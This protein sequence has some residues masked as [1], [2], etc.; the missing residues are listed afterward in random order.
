MS[1]TQFDPD[2]YL[3]EPSTKA[4]SFN[5][6]EYL[7]G[8][9]APAPA[10]PSQ[11]EST[12]RGAVQGVTLGFSDEAKGIAVGGL[13]Y[14]KAKVKGTQ[15][16]GLKS[17]YE[18]ARDIERQANKAAQAAS[19]MAYGAGSLAGGVAS[20]FIPGL[21]IAKGAGLA[22]AAGKSALGAGLSALGEAEGTIAEQARST[23]Q[24]AALGA[25]IPVA[26][27]GVQKAIPG[28]RGSAEVTNK[29]AVK[30]AQ[31]IGT[32]DEAGAAL[33]KRM[34]SNP[35]EH[36]KVREAVKA[37]KGGESLEVVGSQVQDLASNLK[38]AAQSAY[39]DTLNAGVKA[40]MKDPDTYQAARSRLAA[41]VGE[42]ATVLPTDKKDPFYNKA[43]ARTFSQVK[44]FL[45]GADPLAKAAE[46]KGKDELAQALAEG[47]LRARQ[48]VDTTLSAMR[49]KGET[50]GFAVERLRGLRD[51][52]DQ[53]VKSLPGM[54]EMDTLYGEYKSV[55]KVLARNA[56]DKEGNIAPQKLEKFL[57]TGGGAGS[58]S[59]L[60]QDWDTLQSFFAGRGGRLAPEAV[61]V[62]AKVGK[63]REALST[64]RALGR[65]SAET[66][67]ATGKTLAPAL[68]VLGVGL[69]TGGGALTVPAGILAKATADPA[70]YLKAVGVANDVIERLSKAELTKRAL[71]AANREAAKAVNRASE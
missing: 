63:E 54:A 26:L 38:R 4:T 42:L 70:G 32:T 13:E 9:A 43:V 16:E 18:K 14:L 58:Q 37:L 6:D 24:G 71:E 7:A 49:A 61:D 17:E 59:Q 41:G 56:L 5:P 8:P 39:G 53:Q 22:A 44:G 19:P 27:K 34:L 30:G 29:A 1:T 25:A 23:A 47:P 2:A 15:T 51:L 67:G 50:S 46:K 21:A 40:A 62:L 33:Y 12:V 66:G 31:L 65:L 52:L 45:E 55:S 35:D 11:L 60:R 69:S 36:K 48:A 3:A 64:A 68:A 28:L 20:S 57:S 10:A